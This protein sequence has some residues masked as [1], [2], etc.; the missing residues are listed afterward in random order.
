MKNK[1]TKKL[2]QA[3]KVEFV[4]LVIVESIAN[5]SSTVTFGEINEAYQPDVI[6][7]NNE[8][9]HSNYDF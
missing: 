5:S 4:Q 1:A 9:K 2:Y 6:E 8:T 3:P 7:W